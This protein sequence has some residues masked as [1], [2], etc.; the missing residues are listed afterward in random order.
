MVIVN[1]KNNRGN[2]MISSACSPFQ[3]QMPTTIQTR[4]FCNK[5]EAENFADDF[6][7]KHH[8]PDCSFVTVDS[9]G[10]ITISWTSEE[11][12]REFAKIYPSLCDPKDSFETVI[13]AMTLEIGPQGAHCQALM[14]RQDTFD[15]WSRFVKEVDSNILFSR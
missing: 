12:C 15:I 2:Y 8:L 7:R 14:F 9:S 6:I 1:Q 4:T 3:Q 5:T 11:A 13:Q 10:K